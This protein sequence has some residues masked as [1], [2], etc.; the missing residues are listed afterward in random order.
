MDSVT[1]EETVMQRV[2]GRRG[3]LLLVFLNCTDWNEMALLLCGHCHHHPCRSQRIV[4][5]VAPSTAAVGEHL[6][7]KETVV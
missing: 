2:F 7:S 4:V 3:L 5:V 1:L 6:T